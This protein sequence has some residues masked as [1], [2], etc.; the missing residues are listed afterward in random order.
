MCKCNGAFH[1]LRITDND[2][3]FM[4]SVLPDN[5]QEKYEKQIRDN[6]CQFCGADLSSLPIYYYPHKGGWEVEGVGTV[7]LYK[8]CPNRKC[9]YCWALWKLGVKRT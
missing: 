2:P 6:Y 8:K 1:G 4:L 7:W 3:Y 5:L 9:N